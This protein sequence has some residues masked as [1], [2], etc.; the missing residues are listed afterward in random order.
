MFAL[1]SYINNSYIRTTRLYIQ[2]YI[3]IFSRNIFFSLIMLVQTFQEVYF[4]YILHIRN[5]SFSLRFLFK[6]DSNCILFWFNLFDIIWQHIP[7][8][9]RQCVWLRITDE[10]SVAETSAWS[11]LLIQSYFKMVNLRKQKSLF[12]FQLLDEWMSLLAEDMSPRAHV[13]VAKFY[14]R[15][16]LIRTVLFWRALKFTVFKIDSNFNSMS[17]S[18]HPFSL[19]FVWHYFSMFLQHC[20]VKDHWWAFNTRNAR[21]VD[22]SYSTR[23]HYSVSM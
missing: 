4:I 16:R 3:F 1:F 22:I 2:L 23:F 15:F 20:L 12:V 6:Y 13:I 8:F 10:G 21:M 19:Q 14:C 18:H 5:L 17:L 11:I 7:M 9:L